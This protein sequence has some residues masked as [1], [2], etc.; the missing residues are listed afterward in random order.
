MTWTAYEQGRLAVDRRDYEAARSLLREAGDDPAAMLLLG[1]LVGAGL[2][3][4]ADP[5]QKQAWYERAA[6]LGSAEAAYDLG[7]IHAGAQRY[8]TGLSWYLRA[9]ELGDA[10]GLRM[11]GV[12]HAT[13][14]GVPADDGEAE[15]LL[16]AAAAGDVP[17]AAFDLG[18]LHAYRRDDPVEA[19]RWYLEAAKQDEDLARGTWRRWFRAY[20]SRRPAAR[21]PGRC[22][23]SSSPSISASRSPAPSCWRP[24]TRTRRRSVHWRSCTPRAPRSFVTRLGRRH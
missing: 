13:G 16:L 12:M 7:A 9:A 6:E 24:P 14:Q 17:E 11:A 3:G 4:P 23:A 5:A 1:Q 18:A 21:G 20:G 15:R 19:A 2:G 22:W 8:A 10:G